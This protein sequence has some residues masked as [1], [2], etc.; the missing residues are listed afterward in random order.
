MSD[1]MCVVTAIGILV[2]FV[3]G[4]LFGRRMQLPAPIP[5]R[6]RVVVV[7]PTLI[8]ENFDAARDLEDALTER[9]RRGAN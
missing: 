6:D 1:F 3:G 8:Y 9:F 4:V 5:I 7:K 2:A